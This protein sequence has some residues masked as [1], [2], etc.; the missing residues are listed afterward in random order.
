MQLAEQ[1]WA[2]AALGMLSMPELMAVSRVAVMAVPMAASMVVS[3]AV[4]MAVR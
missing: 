2:E 1:A 4:S 3:L